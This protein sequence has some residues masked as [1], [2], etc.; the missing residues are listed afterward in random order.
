MA[1]TGTD[2]TQGLR[3]IAAVARGIAIGKIRTG[4]MMEGVKT[5]GRRKLKRN[6]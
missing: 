6:A 4:E 2:I 3:G 5:I 1:I